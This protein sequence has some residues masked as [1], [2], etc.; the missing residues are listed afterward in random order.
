MGAIKLVGRLA[1]VTL[2]EY[3]P[4]NLPDI[5]EGES[6]LSPGT[7]SI[8]PAPAEAEGAGTTAEREQQ[9]PP[10]EHRKPNPHGPAA[11]TTT[12]C[13]YPDLTEGFHA[14]SRRPGSG[15]PL[16]SRL[17]DIIYRMLHADPTRALHL[18]QQMEPVTSNRIP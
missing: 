1:L 13:S 11:S 9:P 6:P 14:T 15:S 10:S 18:L 2:P 3:D 8:P 4:E 7:G 12:G 16:P 17:H 5:E